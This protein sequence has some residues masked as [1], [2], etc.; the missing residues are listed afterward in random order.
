[1]SDCTQPLAAELDHCAAW[2]MV[3]V[4]QRLLALIALGRH[5]E[6]G[7]NC[8]PVGLQ[9]LIANTSNL[10]AQALEL[11]HVEV[12]LISPEFVASL[13]QTIGAYA[14]ARDLSPSELIACVRALERRDRE[15]LKPKA[16]DLLPSLRQGKIDP[17]V[18]EENRHKARAAGRRM[19]AALGSPS[20][21]ASR[22]DAFFE[23]VWPTIAGIVPDGQSAIEF[24][25]LGRQKQTFDCILAHRFGRDSPYRISS[26]VFLATVAQPEPYARILP[27]EGTDQ[28][29]IVLSRGLWLA[30]QMASHLLTIST[31]PPGKV[32]PAHVLIPPDGHVS[33]SVTMLCELLAGTREDVTY[34]PVSAPEQVFFWNSL[35]DAM[36]GFVLAHEYA[37]FQL[38]HGESSDNADSWTREYQAD[39]QAFHL[40]VAYTDL[41]LSAR[42]AA[43]GGSNEA[44]VNEIAIV[45]AT[46]GACLVLDL[47]QEMESRCATLNS[48]DTDHPPTMLRMRRILRAL[49]GME[50]P[51]DTR[52][53][54]G[55]ARNALRMLLDVYGRSKQTWLNSFQEV[56]LSSLLQISHAQLEERLGTMA[57]CLRDG[58]TYAIQAEP[59]GLDAEL[60]GALERASRTCGRPLIA[61]QCDQCAAIL[62]RDRQVAA[63]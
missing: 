49:G 11:V 62:N 48:A 34:W 50:A 7:A 6:S 32:F 41:Q 24:Y 27:V 12:P 15:S 26:R 37:H 16:Y 21:P 1:M 60:W 28:R 38:R 58:T 57:A 40:T 10:R 31:L 46:L 25:E 55:I 29:L 20:P 18:D 39:E 14:K 56:V 3:G 59:R 30:T 54:V 17:R 23:N 13:A 52:A 2:F 35:D 8:D 47:I 4:P 53:H 5:L 33:E 63:P 22:T 45:Y 43:Q 61:A 9:A 36:K 51:A 44:A 42:M 19:A